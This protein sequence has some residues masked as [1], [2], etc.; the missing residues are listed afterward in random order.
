[1]EQMEQIQISEDMR[2]ST[3]EAVGSL[4]LSQARDLML[5]VIETSDDPHLLAQIHTTATVVAKTEKQE[6]RERMR[7]RAF[8]PVDNPHGDM[9]WNRSR[10]YTGGTDSWE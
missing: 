1:M 8:H 7:R 4:T 3:V 6:R 2:R 5:S 10:G 9:T